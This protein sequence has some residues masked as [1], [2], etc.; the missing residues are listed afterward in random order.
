MVVVKAVLGILLR[1]EH[2]EVYGMTCTFYILIRG[3]ELYN[4]TCITLSFSFK[5]CAFHAVKLGE[6]KE[7]KEEGK[8]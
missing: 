6:R 2:G 7:V 4:G 3:L 5:V 8:K 1:E